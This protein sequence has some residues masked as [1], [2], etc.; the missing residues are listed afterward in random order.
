MLHL[1]ESFSE[2]HDLLHPKHQI[3][4]WIKTDFILIAAGLIS[5]GVGIVIIYLCYRKYR[6]RRIYNEN[7]EA[8][9]KKPEH[10]LKNFLNLA[11]CEFKSLN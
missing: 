1:R 2:N 6:T 7:P 4:N 11:K 10:N 3:T 8:L 5:L 9:S